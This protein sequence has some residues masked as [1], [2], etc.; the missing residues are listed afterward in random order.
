MRGLR[1]R[2]R[3]LLALIWLGAALMV[4]AFVAP[5]HIIAPL[6]TAHFDAADP[7]QVAFAAVSRICAPQGEDADRPQGADPCTLC[8]AALAPGLVSAPPVLAAQCISATLSYAR[9]VHQTRSA[10]QRLGRNPRAPP[11]TV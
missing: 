7:V 8:S 4:Q 5:V 2:D 11:M 6:K 10:A 3:R 1:N 9:A